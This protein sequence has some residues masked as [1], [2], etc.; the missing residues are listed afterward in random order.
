MPVGQPRPDEGVPPLMAAEEDVELSRQTT[1]GKLGNVEGESEADGEIKYEN[2]GKEKFDLVT[3]ETINHCPVY[4]GN[5]SVDCEGYK[6]DKSQQNIFIFV[7]LVPENC[8]T[9]DESYNCW[10]VEGTE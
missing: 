8:S 5:K 9:N 1:L 4:C 6:V 2:S 3:V 7:H 10:H